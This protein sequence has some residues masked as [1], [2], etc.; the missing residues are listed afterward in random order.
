MLAVFSYIKYEWTEH[1]L[2]SFEYSQH[3]TARV[4]V[5]CSNQGLQNVTK[6]FSGLEK[7]NVPLV[8]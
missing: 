1:E 8:E 5:H 3:I 6:Y 2:E 4:D 7:F